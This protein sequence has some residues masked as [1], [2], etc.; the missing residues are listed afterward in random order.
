MKN[1]N[2]FI[3]L[4]IILNLFFPAGLFAESIVLKSG[5]I[6]EG[7]IIE[8][9]DQYVKIESEGRSLYYERKYIKSIEEDSPRPDGVNFYLKS[10]LKYGSQAKFQ[11]AEE[12]FIK[13][14][15]I[16]PS[17]HNLQ[18]TSKIID[19]LKRGVIKEGYAVRLFK[20]S[21]YLMNAEYQ[22]A[23]TEF[24]EA[25]KLNPDDPDLYYYLGVCNYSLEQ[26]EEAITCLKKVAEIRLDGEVYY[27]LGASHYSLG[28]YPQ[29]IAYMEKVL[30]INPD[31]AEAYSVIGTSRYLL[32]QM[33]PAK[34][35]FHKAI[36]LFKNKGDY[37]KAVDIEEFLSKLN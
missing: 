34:E 26:H 3:K 10:G 11:E 27:Y 15:E 6:I 36:G 16:N 8:E 5:K 25:L 4:A 13:G 7:K 14:L 28:Q 21:Y 19:D 20:G 31:D 33:Q 12:E 35:A 30:K 1:N 22:P 9:T 17:E 29:A 24:K 37:L 18:E 23:I 2:R 32:G